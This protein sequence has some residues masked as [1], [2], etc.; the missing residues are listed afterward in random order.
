MRLSENEHAVL[1]AVEELTSD[2]R[3]FTDSAQI[4]AH[5][6]PSEREVSEAMCALL[7]AGLVEAHRAPSLDVPLFEHIGLSRAGRDLL[8]TD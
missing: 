2:P 7:E 1:L 3:D 8:L 4:K 5:S 6:I